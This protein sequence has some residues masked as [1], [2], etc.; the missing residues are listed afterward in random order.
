MKLESV[1]RICIKS[2][3]ENKRRR[4]VSRP[5]PQNFQPADSR[6][7]YIQKHEGWLQS[8]DTLQSGHTISAL[9]DQLKIRMAL[10]AKD[11]SATCMWFVVHHQN[12]HHCRHLL[13][14]KSQNVKPKA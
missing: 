4:A 6:H 5:P 10:K 7:M 11:D 1:Q 14:P 2:R 13:T 12:C 9:A 3:Q 8:F